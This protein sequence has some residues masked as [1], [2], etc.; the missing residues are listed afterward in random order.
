MPRILTDVEVEEVSYV[1]KGANN[2][3]II[4]KSI[5]ENDEEDN[6]KNIEKAA[7]K[8]PVDEEMDDEEMDDEECDPADAK[9]PAKKK[10]KLPFPVAKSVDDLEKSFNEKLEVLTKAYEKSEA[11]RKEE[12]KKSAAT[13]EKN[14]ALEKALQVELNARVT[15]EHVD[16][17]ERDYSR[18]AP[19]AELGPVMKEISEKVAPE[20]FG[21]I[22]GFL[23]AAS[24]RIDA[25]AYTE[26]GKSGVIPGSVVEKVNALVNDRIAKSAGSLTKAMAEAQVWGEH[27]DWYDQYQREMRQH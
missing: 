4:F 16:I 24:D 17:A 21:K 14:V 23:K 20:T 6:M 10:G 8:K 22:T 2:K 25:T 18:I 11:E 13:V 5:D 7:A 1:K 9:G 3:V 15:K 27:V 12:M 26:I 19:A